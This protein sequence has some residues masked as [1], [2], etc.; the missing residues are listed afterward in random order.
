[1]LELEDEDEVGIGIGM[2]AGIG[3]DVGAVSCG[4]TVEGICELSGWNDGIESVK[5]LSTVG[6]TER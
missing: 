6:H 5:A 4:E 2:G 3:A 1:M